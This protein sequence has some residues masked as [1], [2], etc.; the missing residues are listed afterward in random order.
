M[1]AR[2][3]FRQDLRMDNARISVI[4][5]NNACQKRSRTPV[6]CIADSVKC[7]GIEFGAKKQ[8]SLHEE[9]NR[10]TMTKPSASEHFHAKKTNIDWGL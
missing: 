10:N 8:P 4:D 9:K 1:R 5:N 3:R 2:F 6:A 7:L